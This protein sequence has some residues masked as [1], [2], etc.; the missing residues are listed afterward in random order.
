MW[1]FLALASAFFYSFRGIGE[2]RIIS[3][4]NTFILGAA[5]RLFAL[6]F[7]VLPFFFRPQLALPLHHLDSTFWVVVAI[8]SLIN[9]PLEAFCYYEALKREEVTLVLP[10]LTLGPVLTVLFASVFLHELPTFLGVAGVL[11]VVLGIYALKLSQAKEGLL[12]PL[13]VLHKN[14]AVR[15]MLVVVLSQGISSL[16]DKVGVVHSNAYVYALINYVGVSLVLVGIA[17]FKAFDQLKQFFTYAKYFFILGFIVAGY[18]LFYYVALETGFAGYVSAI[19][20]ASL[21]FTMLMG[22]LFLKEKDG[23]Q[24]ILSGILIVIGLIL[25]KIFG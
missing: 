14:T 11:F 8:V 24:K 2:K 18:T 20:S 22:I 3:K 12:E 10:I 15:L 17:I 1:F 6:P 25:L 9:T 19:K 23:K 7:F 4:V 16:F 13:K 21:L 5:V